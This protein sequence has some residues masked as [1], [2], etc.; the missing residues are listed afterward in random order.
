MHSKMFG[1]TIATAHIMP[2]AADY[3]F[4][5]GPAPACPQCVRDPSNT[6][7]RGASAGSYNPGAG[8][9][10]GIHYD[11]HGNLWAMLGIGGIIEYD[12]RGV[13]LGYVPLPN[14]DSAGTNFAFGG[15]TANTFTWRGPSAGRSGVSRRPI[16]A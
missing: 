14:G 9:P 2:R 8:G 7:F 5:R 16:R 6:T 3:G 1:G 15:P 13:I 11:V 12:P 4:L 10:D